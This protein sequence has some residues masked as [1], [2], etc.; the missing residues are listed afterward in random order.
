MGTKKTKLRRKALFSLDPDAVEKLAKESERTGR[1]KSQLVE[2]AILAREFS[3]DVEAW[4][5][6]TAAASGVS[7]EVQIERALLAVIEAAKAPSRRKR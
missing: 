3:P 6:E 7:R 2:D 1:P 4:I 5:A